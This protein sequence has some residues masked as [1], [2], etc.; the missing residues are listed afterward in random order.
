MGVRIESSG[1]G[2]AGL[3]SEV[4]TCH[5]GDFGAGLGPS[6]LPLRE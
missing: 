5:G 6:A 1:S 2:K 3:D 4:L